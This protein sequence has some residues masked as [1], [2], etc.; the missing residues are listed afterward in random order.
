MEGSLGAGF[1]L[2]SSC[3]SLSDRGMLDVDVPEERDDSNGIGRGSD[4]C[5]FAKDCPIGAMDTDNGK[6]SLLATGLPLLI[7][8]S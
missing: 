3:G 6:G 2:K 8:I 4:C 7:S 1:P 5:I